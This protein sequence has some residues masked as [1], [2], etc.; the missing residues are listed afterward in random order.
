MST[1]CQKDRQRDRQTARQKDRQ[2]SRKKDRKIFQL[3]HQN[4]SC[5]ECQL[6]VGK[7]ERQKDRQIGRQTDG[8][9]D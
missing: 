6:D 2:K 4:K 7:I 3:N 9:T 1:G 5:S 8:L